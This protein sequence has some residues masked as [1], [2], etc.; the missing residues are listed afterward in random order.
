MDS[1]DLLI[2]GAGAAGLA[3]AFFR[4][5]TDPTLRIGV[6]EA[7]A[8]A[9][10]W[11][12]TVVRDGYTCEAGPQGFRP[13]ADSDALLAALGAAGD[14]VDAA[15]AAKKRW[16][17]LGGRLVAM[18]AG[19]LQFLA[20]PVLSFPDKLRLLGEPWRRR[21]GDPEE[22]MAGFLARR[23]GAGTRPLA[24]ALAHGIFAGDAARLEMASMFPQAVA[25]EQQHGSLVRGMFAKKRDKTRPRVRR[26]VL[27]SFRAGMSGLVERLAGALGDALL[28]DT[29]LR[30]LQADGDGFAVDL[31]GSRPRRVRAREVVLAIPAPAAATLVAPFDDELATEL[32]QI[33]SASVASVYIGAPR[34]QF[35]HALDGFGC[36]SPAQES[37]LLGVLLCSSVFPHHA[38]ADHALLRV[39]SGGVDHPAEPDRSDHELCRQAVEHLRRLYGFRGEPTF[40]HVERCRNAIAQY[41]AGHR[42]RL[43]RIAARIAH[44]PGLSL[45]GASYRQIAVVGQWT[46]EGSHP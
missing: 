40:L 1:F 15:P 44:H 46:P 22:S 38:P 17:L 13:N 45:L 32:R 39:M 42:R 35:A 43:E 12:R 10:G 33:R 5:R 4:S 34:A 29:P 11:V 25:L 20:S 36:L 7:G 24:A 30:A 37:P 18:P 6:A 19:P 16:V 2:A 31:G 23:F 21:G 27:C 41:E 26:P 14:V 28:L 9:G 8:R 3:H